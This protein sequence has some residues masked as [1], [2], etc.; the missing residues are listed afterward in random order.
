MSTAYHKLTLQEEIRI[1][2]MVNRGVSKVEIAR[3]VGRSISTVKRVL[4]KKLAAAA[5]A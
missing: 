3:R 1:R 2:L 5:R 4:A